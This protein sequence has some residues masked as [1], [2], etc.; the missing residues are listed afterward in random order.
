MGKSIKNVSISLCWLNKT[1]DP[2]FVIVIYDSPL[3]NYSTFYIGVSNGYGKE[4]ESA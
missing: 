1:P 4:N 3:P 2:L